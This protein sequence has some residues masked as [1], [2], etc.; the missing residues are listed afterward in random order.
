MQLL[1]EAIFLNHQLRLFNQ[2]VEKLI[3]LWLPASVFVE[4][5]HFSRAREY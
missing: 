5:T 2:K 4:A 3:F 1:F